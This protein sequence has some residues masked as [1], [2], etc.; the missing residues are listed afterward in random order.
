MRSISKRKVRIVNRAW[1]ATMSMKRLLN[2]LRYGWFAWQLI[3]H[4]LLRWLVPL[5]L[6]V[7]FVTNTLILGQGFFYLFTLVA[8][9]IFYVFALVG[10]LIRKQ[11]DLSQVL[12]VPYYFCLVNIASARGILEAYVGKTYTTWSTARADE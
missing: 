10:A 5:F 9:I 3:S 11:S 2:P 12:Y 1:R 4:K 6:L 7:I 8:Q